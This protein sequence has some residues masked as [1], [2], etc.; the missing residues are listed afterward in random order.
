MK[1]KENSSGVRRAVLPVFLIESVKVCFVESVEMGHFEG[2]G[3][4]QK[5]LPV[6]LSYAW[7]GAHLSQNRRQCSSVFAR[8]PIFLLSLFSGLPFFCPLPFSPLCVLM[9]PVSAPPV[10][11]YSTPINVAENTHTHTHFLSICAS[12]SLLLH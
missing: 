11:H 6:G 2:S 10:S 4:D 8:L 7:T 3:R 9:F 12:S 1:E 5:T